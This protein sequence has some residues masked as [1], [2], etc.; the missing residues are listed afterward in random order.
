MEP[1]FPTSV[2][3]RKR[4]YRGIVTKALFTVNICY[5][6]KKNTKSESFLVLN[7]CKVCNFV[8]NKSILNGKGAK[9]FT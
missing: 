6:K 4:N 2:L 5:Q 9:S 7:T 1:K 3:A 8:L